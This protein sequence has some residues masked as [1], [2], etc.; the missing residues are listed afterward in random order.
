MNKVITLPEKTIKISEEEPKRNVLLHYLGLVIENVPTKSETEIGIVHS[1]RKN[2]D[3]LAPEATTIT[4]ASAEV[5]WVRE[6]IASL[7]KEGKTVGS[8]WYYIVDGLRTAEAEKA[9]E[10]GP[11]NKE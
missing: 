8:N 11:E 9:T 4:L 1:I 10:P 5:D 6:G 2:L 3:S 7:R